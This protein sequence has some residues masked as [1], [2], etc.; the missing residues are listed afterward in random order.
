MTRLGHVRWSFP[1]GVLLV[2]DQG[3]KGEIPDWD[4]EDATVAAGRNAMLVRVLHQMEGA[5]DVHV[6]RDRA[7]DPASIVAFQGVVQIATGTLV[8]SDA[9][10]DGATAFDVGSGTK[11]VEVDV[12]HPRWAS[13]VDIVIRDGEMAS[14]PAGRTREARPRLAFGTP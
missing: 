3:S 4:S 6:W 9:N 1:Y 12:D 2:E 13:R 8:V 11:V 14:E 10:G 5:V 7:D